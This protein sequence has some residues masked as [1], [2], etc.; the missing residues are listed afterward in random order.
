MRHIIPEQRS[1]YS[2]E[3]Q[4]NGRNASE[5]DAYIFDKS[6]FNVAAAAGELAQRCY[7]YLRN[8]LGLASANFPRVSKI[9]GKFLLQMNST[10]QFVRSH[11]CLLVTGMKVAI[12][13]PSFSANRS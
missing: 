10:N 2:V 6:F 12:R 11:R 9:A 4:R 7:V 1:L 8:C 3:T 13:D 5:R